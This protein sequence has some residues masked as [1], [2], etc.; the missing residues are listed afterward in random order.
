[1]A[2]GI[3][4][5]ISPSGKVYIGQSI[6]LSDRMRQHKY[7]EKNYYLKNSLLKYGFK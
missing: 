5:I 6:N 3:Y 7:S 4:R 2:K 1:M